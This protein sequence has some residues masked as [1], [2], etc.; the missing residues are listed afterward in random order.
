MDNNS[1]AQQSFFNHIKSKHASH[2]SF[3]DEIA[4]LLNISNDSAYRRIRGEKPISLDETRVLCNKFQV[5]IDQLLHTKN[6]TVLFS[7][8]RVDSINFRFNEYLQDVANNLR[9]FKTLKNAQIFFFNKDVPL[10]HFMQFPELSAFKFFFWKR[11]LIGY[12]DLA[13][14]QFT[15]AESDEEILQ[16]ATD[17]IN[18]YTGI[19]STE[20]WTEESI[21]VTIR[22]IEYYRYTNIF[23]NTEMLLKVYHQLNELLNHL[24]MQ[25]EIGRKFIYNQQAMPNSQPYHIYINECLLGDNS[26]FVQAEGRQ[27]TYL[28]HNGLNFMGTQDQSFC[29]Y[30]YKNLQN[31]I[32]KS[33]HISLVGA[34]ERSI[35]FNKLREKIHER[36]RSIN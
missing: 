30:T 35:F 36:I 34:K 12:P 4:E 9:L 18:L 20:I 14:Q 13:K 27:I 17:V 8:N 23:I 25:A 7:G 32:S 19:S 1:S 28:N 2:L 6:N 15:G 21:H 26:I 3:V 31:I 22:Q 24:E 5:S 10:F 33:T 29:D 16:I 11:T